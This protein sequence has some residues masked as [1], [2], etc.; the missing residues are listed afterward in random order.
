M[1]VLKRGVSLLQKPNTIPLIIVILFGLL[2][3]KGLIGEG[4]FNMHDD[5]QM[6]RQ[7]QIEK[8]FLDLQIP[9]RWVP[10]MGYG[11]GYPLFNYYPPLP[12]LVGQL[13]RIAGYSYVD[14]AKVLFILSFVVSGITMYFLG[15]EFFGRIGGIVT[16]IFYVWAPYHAVDVYVRGAMNE[17][18]ALIWFPMILYSSYKLITD[19]SKT[20]SKSI[21]LDNQLLKWVVLVA[22]SWFGLFTS[23]NLMV[24]VF[25]PFFAVWCLL[26]LIRSR[27]WMRIRELVYGGAWS[28]GLAAFFS[29]PVLLEKNLVQ[30]NTLVQGYFDYTAHFASI[31]QLLFSRFWGYGASVWMVEE[32]LMSFQIGTY[33]WVIPAVIGVIVA[34]QLFRRRKFTKQILAVIFFLAVGWFAAFLTHNKSIFVW[35]LFSPLEFVQFPWRFLTLVILSFSFVVGYAFVYLPKIV[36]AL[37]ALVMILLAVSYSWNY[38]VPESGQLRPLTD[39]V[40][41]SGLPWDRQQTAGIYDYLPVEAKTAPTAPRSNLV[42]FING[43][44]TVVD[45]SEGTNWA[46]FVVNANEDSLV[47]INQ[48]N[49]PEWQ[50]L[51]NGSEV[52]EFVPEDED[53]GRM[54]IQIPRGTHEVTIELL[55]TPVRVVGN[56]VSV[57][58]WL[59]LLVAGYYLYRKPWEQK[60]KSGSQ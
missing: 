14:T 32:D 19:K 17:S 56:A 40:K 45:I 10:D 39:E 43:T 6:M 26:W 58:S 50:V 46:S 41:F 18:W 3:G 8:C 51:V 49:F 24:L 28:F 57:F 38:F 36:R 4:Y 22:I 54:Y 59:L 15:K 30:T 16:S 33:H 23:H 52:E 44:G 37:L 53:W 27:N 2:A 34:Y 13:V 9:C 35:Q 12:Y 21:K 20:N 47:R 11:Y 25:A 60:R 5:L 31:G 55:D 48:Y 7:L 42:D 1:N 29:L